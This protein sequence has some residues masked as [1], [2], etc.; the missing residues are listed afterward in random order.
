MSYRYHRIGKH[1]VCV[2]QSIVGAIK[3]LQLDYDRNKLQSI[4][5][6]RAASRKAVQI[7]IRGKLGLLK[8]AQ[9]IE[10]PVIG[11]IAMQVHR[12]F[13]VFDLVR[14]E[15]VKV[16]DQG[17]SGEA[18]GREIAA[19]RHA[20][21]IAAAPTF[22][23]EDTDRA[24]YKE[25]Y[26]C[27]VHATEAGFRAGIE[28]VDCYPDVEKCLLDLVSGSQPTRVDAVTHL[29]RQADTSFRVRWLEAGRNQ[30][31]VDEI[32]GYIE[33]LRNW[34]S[35]QP[36][37]GQLQLV[38]THGDFSLVNAI[39]TNSGL[40]FIDWEGVAPGGLFNDIFNFMFVERYYGRASDNF[41]NELE[42]FVGRYRGAIQATIPELRDASL[43]DLTF[44]RRQYYLERLNLLLNRAE[45]PN[46][47]K[48]VLG[49][50][51]LF[52]NFDQ[53]VGD[54]AVQVI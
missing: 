8:Q 4:G 42:E 49:S 23:A 30:E 17:V 18:A 44:A 50:I 21:G 31:A 26:I 12:G 25:E 19:S 3:N 41:L 22:V 5:I 52:R 40:R 11:Q 10:L 2:D 39:S 1:F 32:A 6:S 54:A 33:G 51:A 47:C 7:V 15:V 28:I 48:V 35:G 14:Q 13:K 45:S 38:L 34:L 53:E 37:A 27:G 46:L 43:Q 36:G 9:Q 20:S 29:D 24:W 16:F